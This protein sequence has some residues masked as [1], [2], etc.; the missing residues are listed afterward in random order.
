MELILIKDVDNLGQIGDQVNVKAGYARNYLLPKK[1]AISASTNNAKR[2]AHERRL[3]AHHAALARA[4]DEAVVAKLAEISVTIARKAGEQD[5]LYG[6]VTSLDIE[7]ALAEDGVKLD[8]RKIQLV[9]PIKAVGVYEVPVK[10]RADLA[11][12]LKVWVVAE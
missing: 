1:M 11:A 3:A 12:Q 2:L 4:E 10:L 5:K 6:S 9:E 7:Q 8:R